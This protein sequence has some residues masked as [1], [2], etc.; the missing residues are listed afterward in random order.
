MCYYSLPVVLLIV[1]H[2]VNWWLCSFSIITQQAKCLLKSQRKKL[3]S[4]S[5]FCWKKCLFSCPPG[6][7]I[8]RIK[9]GVASDES[10]FREVQTLQMELQQIMKGTELLHVNKKI[11]SKQHFVQALKF[12]NRTQKDNRGIFVVVL[13]NYYFS[14]K[15][16]VMQCDFKM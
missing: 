8:H 7:S 13:K 11:I 14:L 12:F 16:T 4:W 3:V 5:N 10:Y 15:I 9:R 2:L 1:F 6:L